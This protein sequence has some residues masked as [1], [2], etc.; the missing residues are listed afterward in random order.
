MNSK[1]KGYLLEALNV[2]NVRIKLLE[3]LN[4]EET[5]WISAQEL[6]YYSAI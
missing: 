3:K 4:I 6:I 2:D 5:E 1:I